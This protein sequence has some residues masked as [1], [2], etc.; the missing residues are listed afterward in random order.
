MISQ[1]YNTLILKIEREMAYNS[2][3]YFCPILMGQISY[4]FI[5][6]RLYVPIL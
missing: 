3:I 1:G 4:F 6:V 5:R 2:F